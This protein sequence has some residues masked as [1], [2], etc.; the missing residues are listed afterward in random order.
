MSKYVDCCISKLLIAGIKPGPPIHL[1]SDPIEEWYSGHTKFCWSG[2]EPKGRLQDDALSA[3]TI[4]DEDTQR[5]RTFFKVTAGSNSDY[6]SI[7]SISRYQ[8]RPPA[9]QLFTEDE[10]PQISEQ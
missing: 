5:I 2:V 10:Q 6:E 3:G 4:V 8:A 1:R 7:P 9:I